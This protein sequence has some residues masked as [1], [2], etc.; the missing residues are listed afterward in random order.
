MMLEKTV[1]TAETTDFTLRPT[2]LEDLTEVVALMNDCAA[3]Q[4]GNGMVT[5]AQ[6]DGEW[7]IMDLQQVTRVATT[8]DGRIVGYIEVWDTDPVPVNNW[9]WGRVH[10]DFEGQG[11]GSALMDWAD[12]RVAQ[13][14]ERVPAGLQVAYACSTLDWYEPA[15]RLFAARGLNLTRYFW[16]MVIDFDGP[17]PVPVWPE[18]L[19]LSSVAEQGDLLAVY[20]ADQEAFQDHW[21]YVEQ[22]EEEGFADW[23]KWTEMPDYDPALWFLALDGDEIA[24]LCLCRREFGEDPGMAWISTLAVRK[25]WRKRG[26]GLAL[27]HHA[28]GV[29]YGEGKARAGLGVDAAS[30]TGA[31]RLY[32]K[33]G[34]HV[35]RRY[36][37]YQKIVRPGRD[38]ARRE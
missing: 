20:R 29:F 8:A 11:I 34:M 35:A 18:G 15:K 37:S 22:P 13:T 21:G 3:V 32:E 36:D 4:R 6:I 24:G 38:I 9:V 33:A 16:R 19:R 14:A 27:L 31:T 5:E 12:E 1:E 25:A 7:A 17:P 30:L 26:L 2:R 28:F 23:R 10:P